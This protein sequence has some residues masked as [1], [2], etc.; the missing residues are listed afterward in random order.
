MDRNGTIC[1][2]AVKCMVTYILP[3]SVILKLELVPKL[4]DGVTTMHS[5]PLHLVEMPH[6]I[7]AIDVQ[8]Q[9]Q[10]S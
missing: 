10:K 1:L 4:Y 6:K 9:N 7:I 2:G 5:E 8:Y 3:E